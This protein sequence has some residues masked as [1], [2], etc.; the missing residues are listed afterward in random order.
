MPRAINIWK[1]RNFKLPRCDP[2]SQ[3][4][5]LLNLRRVSLLIFIYAYYGWYK[6]RIGTATTIVR[7]ID[8]AIQLFCETLFQF[9]RKY[10]FSLFFNILPDTIYETFSILTFSKNVK[11]PGTSQTV[12]TQTSNI[13][14]FHYTRFASVKYYFQED[15]D[16]KSTSTNI[17]LP[18]TRKTPFLTK[19]K[20][21]QRSLWHSASSTYSRVGT[22]NPSISI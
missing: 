14:I 16:V 13:H 19:I 4:F 18:S 20:I 10:A 17:R 8:S 15:A 21:T 3:V 1:L 6:F 12:L 2:G 9:H 11:F 5:P 7:S 22:T